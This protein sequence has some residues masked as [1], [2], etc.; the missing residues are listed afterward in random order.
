MHSDD[1]STAPR[2]E[3][4]EPA[5]HGGTQRRPRREGTTRARLITR[6]PLCVHRVL[7]L[8]TAVLCSVVQSAARPLLLVCAQCSATHR[9]G[10][11]LQWNRPTLLQSPLYRL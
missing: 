3:N 4:S 1:R 5:R 6:P 9:A 8:L 7:T 10:A 2:Q 11:A